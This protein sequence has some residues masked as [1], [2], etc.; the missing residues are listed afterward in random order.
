MQVSVESGEGLERRMRVDLPAEPIESDVDKRLQ[1]MARSARL[2]GFRPGKVPVKILRQR[3]GAQ[4]RSDV[5]GEQVNATFPEALSQQQ[6]RPA[7]APRFEVELDPAA[8][9]YAYTAVFEVLPSIELG[10]LEGAVIK[11]PVA[12]VTDED[13]ERMLGQLREQRKTWTEVQRPA[14]EG[15]R[16]TL[17]LEGTIDGEPFQGG[18]GKGVQLELGSGRMI[19]GFESGMEGASPGEERTL[20]LRF[21]DDYHSDDVKGKDVRFAVQVHKV[22]EPLLPEIDAE[23]ARSFG[24]DD[25]DVD[26]L[27]RDVRANMER[28]LRQRIK[29]RVKTQVMDAMLAANPI[30]LPR[31]LIDEEIKA[32]REQTL[33]NA[34]GSQI[35]LPD[36]LFEESARRR[37][38][39]GL[40]IGEVVRANAIEV[41]PDRVRAAVEEMAATYEDAQ[42]VIDY[43]YADK[44]R[45]APVE[46]LTLEDQVVDWALGQARVEDEPSDFASMTGSSPSA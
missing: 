44:Q 26:R 14:R 23:F 40:I 16:I 9:R 1:E 3:F 2:P 12:K 6:L 37:V 4:V 41:D 45:L 43:Y 46:S 30:E 36:V 33:R 17:D 24:I 42:E 28:E 31:A 39:L 13:L 34:G 19:P 25:G 38:A 11:R 10:S 8:G 5:F 21:P 15:D 22:E 35:E 7:G 18:S 32:L 29:D 20:D 27:R